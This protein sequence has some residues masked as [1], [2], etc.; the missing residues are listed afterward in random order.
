MVS[1]TPLKNVFS[2]NDPFGPPSALEP[3]SETATMIV[4]SS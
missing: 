4:L 1:A 3:L 2:L